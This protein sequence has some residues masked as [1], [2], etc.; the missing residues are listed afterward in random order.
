MGV[1]DGEPIPDSVL[2]GST[3]AWKGLSTGKTVAVIHRVRADKDVTISD[4]LVN[5][6]T[7]PGANPEE[8][9]LPMR[10]IG[11]EEGRFARVRTVLEGVSPPKAPMSAGGSIAKTAMPEGLANPRLLAALMVSRS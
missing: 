3:L 5:R 11:G 1:I 7:R 8:R 10:V 6:V 9:V 4:T 2:M